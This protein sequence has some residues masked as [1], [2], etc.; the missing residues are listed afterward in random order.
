MKNVILDLETDGLLDTA[1]RVHCMVLRD[2]DTD[3]VLSCAEQPSYAPFAAGLEVLKNAERVYG[4]NLIKFDR[5]ALLKFMGYQV[6]WEKLRDTLV[7]AGMRWTNTKELDGPLVRSGKLPAEVMGKQTLEAWGHRLGVLKGGYGKAEGSKKRKRGEPE[8]PAVTAKWKTWTPDMQSYC[9]QDTVVTDALIRHIQKCGA[10]PALAIETEQELCDY[11][12]RQEQNG[13]PFY[14]EQAVEL[15]GK[16]SARR[17]ELENEL[18]A[19]FGSWYKPKGEFTP[20][21]SNKA[22][23]YVEGCKATKVELVYFNPGSRQHI[24][25]RLQKLYGWKPSKYTANGQPEVNED[26]LKALP[27]ETPGAKQLMEYLLVTKRLGQL[28]EGDNAWLKLATKDRATGGKLTGLHHIH[29]ACLQSGTITHRA[30]HIWPNLGQ[31]PSVGSP[32]GEECRALFGVPEGWVQ[33]GADAS[34]LELRELSHYM[35]KFDDG[36]YGKTVCEGKNED[37][38]DI[39]SVNRDALGLS[40]KAGR[41]AAKTFIYAFL[42]GSGDL[43]LGQLLGC[44]P[45]EVAEFKSDEKGFKKAKQSLAKRKLPTDDYSASCLMKGGK[46]RARF[47]KNLPALD[48]LISG[49]KAKAKEQGYL[50]LH[51]GRRVP[52][53]YAHAAL[54]SLLQ[55]SGSIVCK[56]WI[57]RFNRRLTQEFGPQ[58]WDGQWA[59]LG[60]IHDEVQIAVRPQIVDRVKAILV[61]EIAATGIEL[62]LRVPL[63]GEAKHGAHWAATH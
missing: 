41:N 13:W 15:Q 33:V 12:D 46:L 60:W 49:V 59:A 17:E 47:L 44:S 52:V 32:Y 36:A 31:V 29:G 48:R 50:T 21:R 45:E 42:Y 39:H 3:K 56:R 5:P 20:K 6:P 4:H 11:L 27:P 23:G 16:L 10:T 62:K 2:L 22:Q 43:N 34:G 7:I 18:K 54:N 38:T 53:R 57:V 25:D 8:D 24:A 19:L 9:E 61:E 51:D 63:T 40:G 30:A 14:L 58:G 26:T 1:T 55:G 35:A 28:A 37:G